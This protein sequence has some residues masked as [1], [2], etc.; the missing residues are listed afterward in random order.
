MSL[1][2]TY[3]M[4]VPQYVFTR[5]ERFTEGDAVLDQ[6]FCGYDDYYLNIKHGTTGISVFMVKDGDFSVGGVLKDISWGDD[7]GSYCR[8]RVI[9]T[10]KD[11]ILKI[12]VRCGRKVRE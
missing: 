8:F 7:G 6:S 9:N 10:E 12:Y 5:L 1:V 3:V 4:N 11:T 2:H